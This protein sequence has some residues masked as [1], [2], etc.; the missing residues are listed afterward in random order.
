MAFE[1]RCADASE[2]L[3][4]I[5]DPD[6][7]VALLRGLDELDTATTVAAR[8]ALTKLGEA[9]LRRAEHYLA[10]E[11]YDVACEVALVLSAIGQ[12]AVETLLQIVRVSGSEEARRW[13]CRVLGVVGDE[14]AV[15]ALFHALDDSSPIVRAAAAEAFQQFPQEAAFARLR[16]LLRD[17]EV[18]RCAAAKT[19]RRHSVFAVDLEEQVLRALAAGPLDRSL[20]ARR[21]PPAAKPLLVR[22]ARSGDAAARVR[23]LEAL[24]HRREDDDVLMESTA[25]P[26]SAVRRAAVTALAQIHATDGTEE[27]A[28]SD[29]DWRALRRVDEAPRPSALFAPVTLPLRTGDVVRLADDEAGRWSGRWSEVILIGEDFIGVR[30]LEHDEFDAIAIDDLLAHGRRHPDAR[31]LKA[32]AAEWRRTLASRGY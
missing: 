17:V 4:S 19:L 25:S 22:I 9:T 11:V 16:A 20:A 23:S 3:A 10:T 32:D 8:D 13:A 5:A 18:V 7:L 21:L 30:G 29:D 27:L 6:E 1:R 14:R 2:R 31:R 26:D 12:P 28:L 24:G 15:P